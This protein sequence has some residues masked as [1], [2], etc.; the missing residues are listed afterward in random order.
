MNRHWLIPIL[1][2]AVL[3]GAAWSEEDHHRSRRLVAQGV[4]LPLQEIVAR[5]AAPRGWILEVELERQG[6]R[7]LYEIELLDEDGQVWEYRVDAA[8]GRVLD[9]QR[10]E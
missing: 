3:G 5:L 10:E 2:G 7:H 9:R 8:D 1:L 6:A 4:I